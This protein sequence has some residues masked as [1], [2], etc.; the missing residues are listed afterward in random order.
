M[1]TCIYSYE[2]LTGNPEPST[3]EKILAFTYWCANCVMILASS[4]LRCPRNK[5]FKWGNMIVLPATRHDHRYS[6]VGQY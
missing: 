6:L 1:F 2:P 3:F 5:Y 4:V